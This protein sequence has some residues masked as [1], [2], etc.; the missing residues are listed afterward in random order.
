MRKTEQALPAEL[1]GARGGAVCASGLP[2]TWLLATDLVGA[3]GL[4][5]AVVVTEVLV[6]L[7]DLGL[8]SRAAGLVHGGHIVTQ[9]DSLHGL[10]DP[11]AHTPPHLGG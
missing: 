3:G 9:G 4:V 10:V 1:G 11:A 2:G 7:G 8:A 5:G 6:R